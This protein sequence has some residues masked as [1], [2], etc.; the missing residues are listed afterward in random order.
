MTLNAVAFTGY[1]A[2]SGVSTILLAR[3][4]LAVRAIEDGA[5]GLRLVAGADILGELAA[6]GVSHRTVTGG[7]HAGL[8]FTIEVRPNTFVRFTAL[9]VVVPARDAG[10]AHCFELQAGVMTRL[11]RHDR[12]W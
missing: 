7:I 11:G 9:D 12:G 8:T 1:G 4:Q 10:Y 6:H 3:P 2:Q 5:Y